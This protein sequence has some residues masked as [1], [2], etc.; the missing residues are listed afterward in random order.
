MNYTSIF[1]IYIILVVL[2]NYTYTFDSNVFP[3]IKKLFHKTNIYN[4]YNKKYYTRNDVKKL[5]RLKL[6]NYSIEETEY[7]I[8]KHKKNNDIKYPQNMSNDIKYP[9]NIS[10]ITRDFTRFL[11]I[12]LRSLSN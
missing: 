4:N 1:K 11:N 8:I 3:I 2:I 6:Y 5:R 12:S 10:N 7:D 9:Q